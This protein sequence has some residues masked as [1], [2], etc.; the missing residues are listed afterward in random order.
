MF[1]RSITLLLVLIIVPA[2]GATP[3]AAQLSACMRIMVE[4]VGKPFAKKVAEAG[5]GLAADYLV[6]KLAGRGD[7][8]ASEFTQQDLVNLRARYEQNGMSECQLRQD[9]QQVFDSQPAYNPMPAYMPQTMPRT[10]T[11]FTMAGSCQ[12]FQSSG[13]YCTCVDMLGQVYPGLAQ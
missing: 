1:K 4:Y 7:A 10:A 2:C 5:A 6:K 9:L 12:V 3:A 8:S 13:S 11:C